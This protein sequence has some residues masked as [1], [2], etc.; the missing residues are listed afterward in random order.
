M[1]LCELRARL[2]Y[3]VTSR[4]VGVVIHRDPISNKQTHKGRE[5]IGDV[6]AEQA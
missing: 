1:D 3:K 5:L 6:A 4:I 2:V